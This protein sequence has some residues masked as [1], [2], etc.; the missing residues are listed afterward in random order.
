[1]KQLPGIIILASNSFSS[2]SFCP[3]PYK[4]NGAAW[5]LRFVYIRWQSHKDFANEGILSEPCIVFFPTY[6][7]PGKTGQIFSA[8]GPKRSR[9]C[10]GAFSCFFNTRPSFAFWHP[11]TAKSFPVE[12]E[13]T[14]FTLW[15][16]QH[17]SQHHCVCNSHHRIKK[18]NDQRTGIDVSGF[19]EKPPGND[20]TYRDKENQWEQIYNAH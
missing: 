4:Q 13:E 10:T 14:R 17:S 19:L 2:F 9:N 6:T 7:P 11:K 12:D 20:R 5:L 15:K 8:C 3:Q 18:G 1:M 16:L